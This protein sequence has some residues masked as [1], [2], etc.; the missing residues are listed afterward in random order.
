MSNP[1]SSI[2]TPLSIEAVARIADTATVAPPAAA[3]ESAHPAVAPRSV[4]VSIIAVLAVIGALWLAQP[5]IVP[6]LSGILL[7]YAMT[8]L[9]AMLDRCHV[10][11]VLGVVLVMGSVFGSIGGGVY[12]VSD[13]IQKIVEQLP[14]AARHVSTALARL[15]RDPAGSLQK[16]QKAA[17]EVEK[18]ASLPPVGTVA[19]AT[20]RA[21][22]MHVVVD[23]PG[24]GVGNF[25]LLSS[26]GLLGFAGQTAMVFFLTFFLLLGG[27]TF[28]RKL[29]RIT[30]PTL[31]HKKI[32]VQ[33]L[34]DINVSIQKYLFML[35][36]TNLLVALLTWAALRAIGLENAGAW[37]V[38]AG[39]LHI[40]PYLGPG[41]TAVAIAMAAFMQ[42]DS[43]PLAMLAGGASLAIATL[44]GTFV[45]TWMTG[46]IASMNSAAV[47]IS[48]LFWSWLWGVSGMLLSIPLIVILKVV[49]ERVQ[50]LHPIAEM[51]GD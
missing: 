8:P 35:L 3:V 22:P 16:M 18:A 17:I 15:S 20:T 43:F 41:V 36:V 9:V 6:L 26:I 33:I 50:P 39:L 51:L 4:A 40:V 25:L 44:V 37:A 27:D 31:S 38:G 14:E 28:K 29:V 47:F 30:G 1:L 11:R 34:D 42:F 10:P 45:T 5:F 49:A 48:L 32:T 13:Q 24:F 21:S 2:A 19:P 23:Q 46:R 12:A 7:A